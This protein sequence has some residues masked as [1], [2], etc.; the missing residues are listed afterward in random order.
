MVRRTL[1]ARFMPGVWVFPGGAVDDADARAPH[2]FGGDGPGADWKVAALRELIEET[3]LWLTTD[4]TKSAPLAEDAFDA[5]EASEYTLDQDALLY[6]SN[7]ITPE[8]LPIRFDT[9]FFLTVVDQDVQVVIDGE[10]LIDFAWIVPREALG[11]EESED[12]AIPF[13]T[14]ETLLLLAT[15]STAD[16]L[17]E[18]LTAIDVVSP[19]QPRLLV[20]DGEAKILLPSD[21]GF[22]EAGLHQRDPTLLER[23]AAVAAGGGRVPAEMRYNR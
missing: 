17:V 23:L 21:E 8:A 10:E 16:A 4:G 14:R 9:R 11:K 18:R 7:W 2:S 12:W 13:P 6:F 3:G 20:G 5:V 19:I 1:T 22:E 15:E